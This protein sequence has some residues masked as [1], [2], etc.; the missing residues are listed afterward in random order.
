MPQLI[1]SRQLIELRNFGSNPGL[2]K[3]WLYLPTI[4]APKTALVVVLH[5]CTQNAA[6]YDHG[7]GWSKLAEEKGFAVLFP[8]QQRAN[9]ANLCFNWFEQSDIRRDAGEALSIREMIGHVVES[10]GMDPDKI[11]IT[12]L[13]A[14]GAMANVMLATYPEVFAGGA[15]IG[16]LAYGTAS[17]VAQAFERMRG[18]NAPSVRQMQSA[19]T[20][21]A[22]SWGAC[23]SISV[24]HGTHDQ[25]VKPV[26]AEQ[27]AHQWAG[28]HR[29]SDTPDL[30]QSIN[31]HRRK[32]WLNESGKEVIEVNLIKGMA[33]GVPLSITAK[34]PLGNPGPFMLEAG[35]SSTARIARSWG[36]ADEADVAIAEGAFEPG[37]E[38]I[39]APSGIEAVLAKAMA[40]AKPSAAHN[41]GVRDDRGVGKVIND[42]LRA[43]GLMR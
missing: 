9:N 28:V 19:L 36:L 13:S 30:I 26:N 14:G 15:I 10:H 5:G 41:G 33:H 35:I 12:G 42:A 38:H 27:I 2:L 7:S 3:C 29:I 20:T 18:R 43:A 11:F 21:A 22:S 16:G 40:Y 24:W 23:P 1:N 37:P 34:A 8:E 31:G 17:G 25:T 6:T 39:N 4:L 32:V